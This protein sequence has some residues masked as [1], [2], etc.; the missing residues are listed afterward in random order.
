VVAEHAIRVHGL[1]EL[2]GVSKRPARPQRLPLEAEHDR[3][4]FG[5]LER[6]P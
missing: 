1:Y 2:G 6:R 3:L 5:A 4:P